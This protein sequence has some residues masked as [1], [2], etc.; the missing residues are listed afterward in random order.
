M[1]IKFF[2]LLFV[3]SSVLFAEELYNPFSFDAYLTSSFGENRG[4][5]YHAGI[6]FSTEMEEGFAIFA[7]ENGIVKEIRVSP[8][9]YGKV[10][11]FLGESKRIWVFAHLSNF[12]KTLDS[13]VFIKQNQLQKN[14]VKIF[15]K[16]KMQKGDT[17]AFSGSTGIGNPHLHL[18]IRTEKNQVLSPCKNNVL[19]HDTLA[20]FLLAAAAFSDTLLK[21]TNEAALKEGCLERPETPFHLAFKVVD[22]SRTP[23]EN[24]MSVYRVELFSD[25]SKK[26]S[27]YK[28][29]QDTLSYNN[30][31]QIREELLFA[32]EVDTA[33]DYHYIPEK[34]S[35]KTKR[36]WLEIEDFSSHVT[37]YSFTLEDSCKKNS[38]FKKQKYG[39]SLL[40]TFLSRPVISFKNCNK[41]FILK[42]KNGN[43]LHR[44]LCELYNGKEI[45]LTTLSEHFK[46]AMFLETPQGTIT[47]Y[48]LEKK[49]FKIRRDGFSL[50]IKNIKSSGF[51]NT[52]A[53]RKVK[54]DSLE[55]LEMH[56]KGL[57]FSGN[58]TFCFETN[59]ENPLYYLGETTRRWF[60]FS[61]QDSK[62]KKRCVSMNEIRDLAFIL[63]T[64][65][66]KISE[67]YLAKAKIQ[68]NE[69]EV[70]RIPVIET[71]SGI[72]NGN[73][74]S[75][76]INKKWTP[77]EYDSETK[78]LILEKRFLNKK[79]TLKICLE[80]EAGN[81]CCEL[82]SDFL[83]LEQR[84]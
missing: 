1:K 6:D 26:T 57:H 19:C 80:D 21:T 49:N 64:I 47:F 74:F 32:E 35:E 81:S 28:K 82:L 54:T 65:P 48:P 33:G 83:Y 77:I 7:P 3:F 51:K 42:D 43:V 34:I 38:D 24:P 70:Y 31:I 56:P 61:K 73:A 50:E 37:S 53:Y 67:P 14:D 46:T 22:Y 13:L 39:D 63:D 78:E 41:P 36:L 69:K 76:F 2:L 18:E 60:Y 15:P 11:Y 5:R 71:Q 45:W 9:F 20:P 59:T 66:P 23:L 27:V 79:D 62:K 8:Y 4:T 25:S 72:K 55:Y 68:G 17:L 44:N 52:F 29:I 10:L 58:L 12:N 75:A 16:M 84:F 30:M 40:F